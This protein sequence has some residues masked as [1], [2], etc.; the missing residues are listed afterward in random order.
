ML[1]TCR[2][3][4][5]QLL[6][7]RLSKVGLKLI[8]SRK[9]VLPQHS[10][11][12]FISESPGDKLMTVYVPNMCISKAFKFGDFLRHRPNTNTLETQPCPLTGT[13][14]SAGIPEQYK[15]HVN[16]GIASTG[17][18]FCIVVMKFST[19]IRLGS[20][21]AVAQLSRAQPPTTLASTA[22]SSAPTSTSKPGGGSSVLGTCSTPLTVSGYNNSALPNPFLF[23]D[24][25][26]VQTQEEWACRRAQIASLI[27][28]YEAGSLP[29]KPSSLSANF[30]QSGTT[31]TLAITASNGGSSITFSPTITYPSGTAPNDGGSIPIPAGIATLTYSNSDM[32]QQNSASSRGIGLFYN[33]YGSSHNASAM[34][35]W[36]WGVSRII[37]ILES[38]PAANINTQKIAVTGC[39]RDGKGALMAGAFETRIALTVPQESGSGGDTC[40][41][42]SKFEQDS[43]SVVQTATEIV[44][45]NVW[46]STAFNNYVNNL[47]QL[48]YDHH[49]LLAMVAPRGLI[50]FENTDFVWLSPLSSWGCVSAARTVYQ[51]LGVPDN[52]GFEQVGGHQHCQWPSSLTPSLNA[53]FD[54]FLLG[55]STNT[56]DF[57]STNNVF[58]GV[59]WNPAQW[60]NWSTPTLT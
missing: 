47:N 56:S 29:P 45:E 16:F 37:D 43:G 58:G 33:L 42:L 35:A 7:R 38:T 13:G 5:D 49:L 25:T 60:I 57:F 6:R 11:L 41:R 18:T 9:N 52:H 21:F 50:S 54:K 40:W 22:T 23:D 28:G 55:G 32:A 15:K 1:G 14:Q 20:A 3:N 46:F 53:F 44:G 30:T 19:I 51:A 34:T 27:Q 31:G 24:G 2:K 10:S 36:V 4:S 12:T 39:S 17:S 59:P 8:Q 26:P 48:P